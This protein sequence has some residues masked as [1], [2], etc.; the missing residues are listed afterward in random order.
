MR[1]SQAG[2]C[3]GRV[4]EH[5]FLIL[6]VLGYFLLLQS[7]TFI[8]LPLWAKAVHHGASRMLLIFS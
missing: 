8:H 4:Y 5:E 2:G 7:S 6:F 3:P 1:A